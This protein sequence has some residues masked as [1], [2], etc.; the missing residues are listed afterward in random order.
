ML[1]YEG[2]KYFKIKL[3]LFGKLRGAYFWSENRLR[4]SISVQ[5]HD[6]IQHL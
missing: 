1:F 6:K 3:T 4:E 5:G 2:G